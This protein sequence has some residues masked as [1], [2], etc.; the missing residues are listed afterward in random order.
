MRYYV[1][2]E[3]VYKYNSFTGKY[4]Y[5]IY[6]RAGEIAEFV[7]K[8]YEDYD[9]EQEAMEKCAKLNAMLYPQPYIFIDK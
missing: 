7:T 3:P 6:F 4:V 9:T 2:K 1:M 5:R 8:T